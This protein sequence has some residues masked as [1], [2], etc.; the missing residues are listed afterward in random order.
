M[1][2]ELPYT[3]DAPDQPKVENP[4]SDKGNQ[5]NA[6]LLQEGESKSTEPKD[7][8][9]VEADFE[10]VEVGGLTETT[11]HEEK[12]TNLKQ[13]LILA[14]DAVPG[15]SES[16]LAL[17][18]GSGEVPES[19]E[20]VLTETQEVGTEQVNQNTELGF[21]EVDTPVGIVV[22][23]SG[24]TEKGGQE[25]GQKDKVVD[26]G[27][28]VKVNKVSPM[29]KLGRW[30][31]SKTGMLVKKVLPTPI[32]SENAQ[33]LLRQYDQLEKEYDFW[34]NKANET[35]AHITALELEIK[36][37]PDMK[38][39]LQA[40]IN[41]LRSEQETIRK[42]QA[43]R[44]KQLYPL[45]DKAQRAQSFVRNQ[46]A[47][48]NHDAEVESRNSA[49]VI[50]EASMKTDM[51]NG[52]KWAEVWNEKFA[53]VFNIDLKQLQQIGMKMGVKIDIVEVNGE[54][55]ESTVWDLYQ[56]YYTGSVKANR[57]QFHAMVKEVLK[58][59]NNA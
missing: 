39:K 59:L 34:T 56:T 25:N 26:V 53:A 46:T 45:R 13:E 49:D 29:S 7:G 28:E 35:T 54:D 4:S 18:T 8:S 58:A 44:E 51:F 14:A 37:N 11:E 55:F 38:G 27:S 36:R 42:S 15:E 3:P 24:G 31:K 16:G 30:L 20:I 52:S 48:K 40:Q 12:I 1:T 33:Q 19:N 9:V 43:K 2:Y 41:I 32:T 50:L 6:E 22:G 21:P 23:S 5:G 10:I 17:H 47:S 57:A